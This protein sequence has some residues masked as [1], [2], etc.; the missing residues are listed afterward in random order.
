M[1]K[2]ISIPTRAH[3]SLPSVGLGFWKIPNDSTAKLALEAAK[4]GYRHF[5]CASDY[6]NEQQVGEGINQI[7]SEGICRR[8]D[9]WV[10]GK[11]WN[12]Y[13]RKEHVRRACERSLKDL[14]ID[15]LDLYLIHFPIALAYVPFEHRYPAGWHYDPESESP[16]MIPDAVP[17]CETWETMER[18]V[19]AGLV[20]TVGVSNFGT[21]LLRDVLSYASIR[22][23]VLQVESHPYLVQSKLLR[24]C[25]Q[26]QIAVTAFSPL[27]A[28]SY[29]PLGMATASESVIE[30]PVVAQIAQ[31][32]GRTPAQVVLRWGVQR[33]T[34]VIPKTQQIARL[35]EN[36]SLFDF[37]LTSEHMEMISQL[38]R[39]QRFNDPGV[40]C[41]QAFGC[42]Y[43]IYE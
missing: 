34:A 23:S 22:P 35:K 24:Y 20:R 36:L 10:T 6:G 11:L 1:E 40:F 13:H 43:P 25:Q 4:I 17:I 41:E 29:I 18:L 32:V 28:P 42:Y 38:D 14:Q 3:R 19:Q 7:L 9:L 27:G 8:E 30:Q 21:S 37:E 5:D 31:E 15:Y 26:E 39:N 33:G 2:Q 16:R 12:T